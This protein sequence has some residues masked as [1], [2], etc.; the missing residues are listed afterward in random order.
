MHLGTIGSIQ[1]MAAMLSSEGT[2][3][4]PLISAVVLRSIQQCANTDVKFLKPVFV[5]CMTLLCFEQFIFSVLNFHSCCSSMDYVLSQLETSFFL[6]FR[7]IM[8][9]L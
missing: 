5:K 9:L 3:M 4:Y 8:F 1:I 2:P 7:L 6:S